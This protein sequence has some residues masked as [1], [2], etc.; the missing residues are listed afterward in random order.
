[1]QILTVSDEH[2]AEQLAHLVGSATRSLLQ[3]WPESCKQEAVQVKLSSK[4]ANGPASAVVRAAALSTYK[5]T[6]YKT[7]A[8]DSALPV[9]VSTVAA[10]GLSSQQAS[11]LSSDVSGALLARTVGNSRGSDMTPMVFVQFLRDLLHDF[12]AEVASLTVVA[13]QGEVEAAGMGLLAAVGRGANPSQGGDK[14]PA[15]AHVRY[16]GGAKGGAVQTAFVGKGI[17]F[18]TGGLNLKPTGAIEGMHI[19]MG[20][21]AAVLGAM[22]ST[23]SSRPAVNVDFVFSLAENAIGP[24]AMKP[25][26]IVQGLSGK[27]VEVGNTDAEGRLALA[28]AMS[29]VQRSCGEAPQRIVDVGTLTGACVVALGHHAAGLFS[30][31]DAL[32]AQLCASGTCVQERLWHMPVFPEHEK[33]ITEGSAHAD[34]MSIGTGR[35]AGACTAAAFLKQFVEEGVLWAHLDIAGPGMLPKDSGVYTAGST[36]FAAQT[37]AAYIRSLEDSSETR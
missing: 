23:L 24:E 32:A 34:L 20:G 16:R 9:D 33:E 18:D 15:L 3:S 19:D 37:L 21:A 26:D 35:E 36:G 29:Y 22:V 28:D 6:P 25:M 27:T 30:N 11:T 7:L 13:G 5:F 10:N 12:P 17:T 31:N 1:M 4:V 14:G 2:S 8:S